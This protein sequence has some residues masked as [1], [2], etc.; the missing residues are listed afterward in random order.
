MYI[1]IDNIVIKGRKSKTYRVRVQT[2]IEKILKKK[3]RNNFKDKQEKRE[4]ERSIEWSFR[5]DTVAMKRLQGSRAASYTILKTRIIQW[6]DE[7]GE[8]TT[9]FGSKIFQPACFTY[10]SFSTNGWLAIIKILTTLRIT[11]DIRNKYIN[12]C[13]CVLCMSMCV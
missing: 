12:V 5:W 2:F 8:G 11:L 6:N 4:K 9:G 1:Q 3:N 10:W 7:G 13:T